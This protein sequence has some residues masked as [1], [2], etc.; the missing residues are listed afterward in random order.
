MLLCP[1]IVTVP[2]L[3]VVRSSPD[4]GAD[5]SGLLVG[6]DGGHLPLDHVGPFGSVLVEAVD[7]VGLHDDPAVLRSRTVPAADHLV[8]LGE[9]GTSGEEL[10]N[11]FFRVA[12]KALERPL[13]AVE[14]HFY[15]FGLVA[16][17]RS[18]EKKCE[19]DLSS[20]NEN[21][22]ALERSFF[23]QRER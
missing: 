7:A 22:E 21:E 2:Y 15:V 17:V 23:R 18:D 9:G 12:G 5:R 6:E 13:H 8:S 16:S 14:R 3:L 4:L 20:V 11:A 10:V 1:G 19:K